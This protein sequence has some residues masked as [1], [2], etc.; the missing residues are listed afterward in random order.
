MCV[1]IY[2]HK[3][4]F[5]LHF[6]NRRE[7][8]MEKNNSQCLRAH[9]GCYTLSAV[10][11]LSCHLIFTTWCDPNDPHDPLE[12]TSS[13]GSRCFFRVI[14]SSPERKDVSPGRVALELLY[15]DDTA[16]QVCTVLSFSS[17][18]LFPGLLFFP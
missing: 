6:V 15:L 18:I 14:V 11:A 2:I 4:W 7:S 1:Y 13:E 10:P 12:G 16:A 17:S 3:I 8:D 5:S 9:V